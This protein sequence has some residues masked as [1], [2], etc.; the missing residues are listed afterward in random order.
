MK[1]LIFVSAFFFLFSVAPHVFAQGFVPLAPIPGLTEVGVVKMV[2][3]SVDFGNFFNNLY[4]YCVGLAAAL[5]VIMIIWGGLEYATQDVPGAKGAGKEKILNAIFGLVLVLSPVLVFSIINPRILNLS[6]NL[7]PLDLEYTPYTPTTSTYTLP[8]EDRE[9]RESQGGRVL[10]GFEINLV[11][12]KG[13]VRSVLE[14]K[15]TE[16]TAATGGPGLILPVLGGVNKYVCQTCPPDK[17]VVLDPPGGLLY[18]ASKAHG[19]CQ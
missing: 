10:Y 2:N 6:L 5:A 12:L 7:P 9:I 15:Q 11:T 14:Q 16:C 8:A 4:K 1:K 19:S 17:K 18:D 13:T 3:G